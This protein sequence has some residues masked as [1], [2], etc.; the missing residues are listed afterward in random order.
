M[1]FQSIYAKYT[2][3][4][5]NSVTVDLY[6]NMNALSSTYIGDDIVPSSDSV[7]V[8]A[9]AKLE[10][11]ENSKNGLPTFTAK[12][13]GVTD[14][15]PYYLLDFSSD[16]TMVWDIACKTTGI[17]SYPAGECSDAPVLAEMGFDGSVLPAST[18]TFSEAKFGGYVVSGTKYE[19]ELC[20]GDYN[21]KY[22]EIYDA[23]TVSQNDWNF[24]K[25]GTYGIIGMGPGSYIW[26]G[27]VDPETKRT[28]FSI[29]LARSSSYGLGAT[30]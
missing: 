12:V 2:M 14:A 26:E 4:G 27:F 5:V 30:I 3:S 13:S 25:D 19:S 1:F 15:E 23:Q 29:E 11:S 18:A 9:V 21:C 6:T 16:R 24:N 8:P 7:F 17:G 10:P 20:F 22:V 28:V